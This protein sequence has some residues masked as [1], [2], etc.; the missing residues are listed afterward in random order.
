MRR[1]KRGFR[2]AANSVRVLRADPELLALVCAGVVGFAVITWAL[3][4][5]WYGPVGWETFG[6]LSIWRLLPAY[7][8]AGLLPMYTNAA[9]VAA[10][11]IRLDG[12]DPRLRDGLRLATARLP[13]L[14][15]WAV[16]ATAVG[17]VIQLIV[18]RLNMAGRLV[19]FTLGLSWQ[20]ATMFVV[21]IILFEDEDVPDAVRGSA[22]LFKDRWGEATAGGA[23][24]GAAVLVAFL[25]LMIVLPV[26]LIMMGASPATFLAF[27]DPPSRWSWSPRS[28]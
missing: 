8:I 16:V 13:R 19:G 15:I 9:V 18:E 10:A 4:Q 26:V 23:S 5:W 1:V 22:R 6:E 11:M 2:L 27:W 14:L 25:P 7:A 3:L 20:L 21:P 17:A 12:G 24:I 28:H